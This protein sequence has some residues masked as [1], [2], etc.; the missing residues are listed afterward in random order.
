MNKKALL[1]NEEINVCRAQV[2]LVF[3]SMGT[4]YD[5]RLQSEDSMIRNFLVPVMEEVCDRTLVHGRSI[6][7]GRQVYL[8]FEIHQYLRTVIENYCRELV[9]IH[10]QYFR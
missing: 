8:D 6:Q 7:S 4:V 10:G 1:S 5:R 2:E 3:R 9:K